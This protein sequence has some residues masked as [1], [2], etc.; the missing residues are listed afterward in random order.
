MKN[1]AIQISLIKQHQIDE[2]KQLIVTV[3]LEIWDGLLSEDDIIFCAV[4]SA[5][6]QQLL[7]FLAI[8]QDIARN[9]LI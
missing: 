8:K 6:L 5:E 9:I 3:C 2:V 7:D 4:S 1:K